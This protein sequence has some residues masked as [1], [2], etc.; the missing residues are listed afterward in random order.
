MGTVKQE[1]DVGAAQFLTSAFPLITKNGTNIPVLGLLYDPATDEAA[2]WDF[3]AHNYGSGNLTL[4]IY[5]YADSADSGDVV[6]EAQIAAI[7]P[8]ADS[9]DVETDTLAAANTV[10][11]SHLGTTRQREH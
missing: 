5:W 11:D 6:W 10:T 7:T 4:D 3:I 2:F 1:F 8:N 9:Q